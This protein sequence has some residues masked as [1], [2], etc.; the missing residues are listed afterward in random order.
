MEIFSC[1][2]THLFEVMCHLYFSKY[3]LFIYKNVLL[4][5]PNVLNSNK[6]FFLLDL[7]PYGAYPFGM[8]SL[9]DVL[10]PP[11]ADVLALRS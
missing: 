2:H 9:A 11:T 6:D 1:K 4:V 5:I 7:D 10:V 8:F 3:K